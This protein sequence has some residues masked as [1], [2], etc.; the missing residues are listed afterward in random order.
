MIHTRLLKGYNVEIGSNFV[1]Y[2]E[3]HICIY[4]F[5]R[6]ICILLSY[7]TRFHFEKILLYLFFFETEVKNSGYN[8]HVSEY[9][10][11]IKCGYN[12]VFEEKIP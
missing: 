4:N 12:G 7:L 5:I 2:E 3:K 8:S 9:I 6:S 11:S 10:K 1:L